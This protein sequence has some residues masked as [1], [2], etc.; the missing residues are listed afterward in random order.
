MRQRLIFSTFFSN[1]RIMEYTQCILERTKIYLQFQ[2]PHPP[3]NVF[4]GCLLNLE[5]MEVMEM[6]YGFV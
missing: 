1:L 5:I 2:T 6:S 3:K 4:T